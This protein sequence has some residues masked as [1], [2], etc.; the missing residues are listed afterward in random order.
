MGIKW[1]M[2]IGFRRKSLGQT[3]KKDFG[4][5][6]YNPFVTNMS[7]YKHTHIR[8]YT[9]IMYIVTYI[10]IVIYIYMQL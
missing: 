1:D 7:V 5:G 10:Y 9:H 8:T 6:S 3:N 4:H 2:M